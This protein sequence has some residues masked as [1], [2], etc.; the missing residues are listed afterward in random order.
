MYP[1]DGQARPKKSLGQNFLTEKHIIGEIVSAVSRIGGDS[2]LE[3]GPGTGALTEPLAGL[4]KPLV[5][6][7]ADPELAGRLA[8]RFADREDVTVAAGD[9]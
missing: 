4:G 8:D 5:C 1:R 6:V 7:E 3:I 9:F 2:V